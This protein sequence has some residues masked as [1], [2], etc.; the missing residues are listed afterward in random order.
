MVGFRYFTVSLAK[1]YGVTGL[2]K[3][4]YDGRVEIEAEGKKA[5][6]TM[7]LEDVRIGPRSARV[8]NVVEQW[9]EISSRRYQ[10]FGV[11]F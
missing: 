6:L 5:S 10:E 9:Q 3:N 4:L 8:E 7:F 1:R 2:V 11:S